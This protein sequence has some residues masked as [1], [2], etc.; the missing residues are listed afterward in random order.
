MP[1]APCPRRMSGQLTKFRERLNCLAGC[2]ANQH[3]EHKATGICPKEVGDMPHRI[4]FLCLLGSVGLTG[5]VGFGRSSGTAT[6]PT[7]IGEER[8]ARVLP[9]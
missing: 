4:I 7:M 5:C 3:R 2:P 9:S 8:G 6:A 1:I